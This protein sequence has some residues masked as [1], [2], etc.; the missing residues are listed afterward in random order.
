MTQFPP[1]RL[2][3]AEEADRALPGLANGEWRDA[4][5]AAA[6]GAPYL[7]RLCERWRDFVARIAAAGPDAL[8]ADALAQARGAGALDFE[9]GMQALRAA[10]A[11][12]HLACAVGDIAGRWTLAGVTCAL[13]ELADAA[14]GSALALAS[15]VLIERGELVGAPDGAHGPIPGLIMLALGK[16]GAH[17]LNYSSDI[18]VTLF[19]DVER[20]PVAP[21]R[22]PKVVAQKVV[23]LLARALDEITADGYVFRTDFRLRPDPASTPVVVSTAAA[24]S[25]YQSVGQNWERAALIKARPCA[26]DIEA[27]R[28]FLKSIE[29]FI[30]R[31]HL[32][33]AAI[34]DVHSIKRQILAVHAGGGLDEPAPDVKLG[35]GGIRDI[36]LFAQTQQLILGGRDR[37][38]RPRDTIGALD[39]LTKAGAVDPPTRDGLVEAYIFLR[40]VEHRIQ[41]LDDEQ[42]QR[43][44]SGEKR[45]RLAALCGCASVEAF[46]AALKAHRRRVAEIDADLFQDEQT[47]ADPLGSLIFTGVEN[48]PETLKTLAKLGFIRPDQVADTVRG[49]HHGRIRA[50]RTERA[51]EILTAIMPHLLRALADSGEAD[52]AFVHFDEFLR[53]LPAGVQVFSLLQA[54]PALLRA[55]ADAFGL[56]P[57]LSAALARRPSLIDAALDPRF[58]E[59]LSESAP[60]ERERELATRVTQVNFE[61]AINIARRFHAE[62]TLRIGLQVLQGRASAR[63]SGLAHADLAQACVRILADAAL[64]ETVRRFG[65]EP[66]AFVVL[67]LGKF[68]GQEM[69]EGSDLDVMIVY[70]APSPRGDETLSAS[71][72]YTRLTQRL[73]SALSAPTEEGR[74]YDVDMQLRPSGSAGPVAVRLSSFARYY[75]EEAWTWELQALTR[76]RPVAGDPALAEKTIATAHAALALPRAVATLV[77]DVASMRARMD[78]ERPAKSAWDLKLSPGGVVD[79]EFAAQALL[80]AEAARGRDLVRANTAESLLALTEAGA[81]AREDYEALLDGLRLYAYLTQILRIC[82]DGEFD[83]AAASTRLKALLAATAG[84]PNFDTLAARLAAVQADLRE[85]FAR[86]LAQ[87]RD[88]SRRAAR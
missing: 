72:F 60:G 79:I 8:F 51:R 78:K 74:L 69:A 62:E 17:E 66:G 31:R 37:S 53:N 39:A 30:W 23:P 82:V 81:L 56:A 2:F 61:Q 24:E 22:E 48:D 73:I 46:D 77:D 36:E 76:A 10:K 87:A 1:A 75:A 45:E 3:S 54:Q 57:R 9:A 29:P 35:R 16:Q 27:G 49:W 32:D 71:E 40:H 21:G 41:M 47:L 86:L 6:G 50:T 84:D 13:T 7:A 68:G 58:G 28:D 80:L 42:T 67:A 85:R 12:T 38:L 88:G 15:R 19:A 63:D 34:A 65:P 64:Q 5:R 33:Y 25:Y 59:A 18:D 14:C 44:P 55:L 83:P 70:D 26:G 4:L 52:I 11:A 43:V 20:L